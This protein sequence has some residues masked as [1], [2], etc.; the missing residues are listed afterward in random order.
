M[1][2]SSMN[3]SSAIGT[4]SA[5][6]PRGAILSPS[7]GSVGSRPSSCILSLTARENLR[8]SIAKMRSPHRSPGTLPWL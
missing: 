7:L 1:A 5:S 6:S 8:W 3:E 2:T 4:S